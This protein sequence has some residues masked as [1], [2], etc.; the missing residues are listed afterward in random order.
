MSVE[1]ELKFQART[2][3]PPFTFFWLL[4]RIQPS[5]IAVKYHSNRVSALVPDIC[6][7]YVCS[8][9]YLCVPC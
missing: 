9:T 8:F 3:A 7:V 4:L 1:R 5:K 6:Q 2:P